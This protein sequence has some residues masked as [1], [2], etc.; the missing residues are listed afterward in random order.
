MHIPKRQSKL[1]GFLL[2]FFSL[3]L[4]S[5]CAALYGL[6]EE[7]KISIADIQIQ[8][9]KAMEGV[10]LIKLRILNPNDV[11]IDL[12]G[13]NCDLELDGRHFANGIADSKQTVA[14]YGTAIIPVTV[15]ASVLDM[16]SS[17]VDLIHTADRTS[18]KGKQ[19][20]YTLRGTVVV[21]THGFQKEIPFK[22]AGEISLK[23]L[24]LSR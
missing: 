23:G 14:A 13:I 1:S 6:K 10:F 17:A 8:D 20:P 2:L 11:P 24:G 21:A 7:P 16:I 15:Y 18:S 3:L 5:G 12:H 4:L 9:V 19:L 22:S